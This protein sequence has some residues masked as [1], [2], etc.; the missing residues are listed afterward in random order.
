MTLN[1]LWRIATNKFTN[2]EIQDIWDNRK[3]I[4]LKNHKDFLKLDY[5]NFG[6]EFKKGNISSTGIFFEF[7][8]KNYD[9]RVNRFVEVFK[10]DLNYDSVLLIPHYTSAHFASRKS[11]KIT[12]SARDIRT[13]KDFIKLQKSIAKRFPF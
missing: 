1:G 12:Q 2:A 6:F 10:N 11:G 3:S 4:E 9:L 7:K 5:T 13:E 8:K